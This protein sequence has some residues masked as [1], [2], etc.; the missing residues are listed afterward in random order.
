M[1]S[2]ADQP[3]VQA[4][5]AQCADAVADLALFF[6][7]APEDQ[8][9]IALEDVRSNLAEQWAEPFGPEVAA[10]LAQDFVAAVAGRRREIEAE[11]GGRIPNRQTPFRVSGKN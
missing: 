3:P 10:V 7:G 11:A 9:M 2:D 6:A 1:G 4:F 5:I 8:M